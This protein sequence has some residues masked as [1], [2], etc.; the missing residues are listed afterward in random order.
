MKTKDSGPNGSSRHSL[1]S[2]C[3][4]FLHECSFDIVASFPNT[5]KH[6]YI[7]SY[8]FK[9]ECK[10]N[11]ISGD[12]SHCAVNTLPLG[13]NCVSFSAVLHT[14]KS[15]RCVCVS[16]FRWYFIQRI[17]PITM[18]IDVRILAI[19]FRIVRNFWK[20]KTTVAVCCWLRI[21]F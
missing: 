16:V 1:R 17:K 7:N 2:V 14:Y 10:L 12:S 15:W 13:Y 5:H 9:A 19:L 18:S 11:F 20:S 21:L 4:S 6:V 8:H 3:S